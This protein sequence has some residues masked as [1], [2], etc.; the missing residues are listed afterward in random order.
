MQIIDNNKKIAALCLLSKSHFFSD[1]YKIGKKTLAFLMPLPGVVM[2]QDESPVLPGDFQLSLPGL[3][4]VDGTCGQVLTVLHEWGQSLGEAGLGADTIPALR[5]LSCLPVSTA[6][7]C[8][9][10]FRTWCAHKG[11]TTADFGFTSPSVLTM[12]H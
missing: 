3:E 12:P 6:M 8:W 10:S 9:K 7:G 4:D 1:P 2:R 5:V 11:R